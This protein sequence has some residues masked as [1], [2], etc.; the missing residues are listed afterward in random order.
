MKNLE[1]IDRKIEQNGNCTLYY[2]CVN[3]CPHNAN[4]LGIDLK[5]IDTAA[6][7]HCHYDHSGGYDGFFSE[8]SKAKVY[9]QSAVNQRD[10]SFVQILFVRTR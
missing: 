6:L 8:N 3:A 10:G 9:L 5:N 4:K 2:R 1:Q 7:S